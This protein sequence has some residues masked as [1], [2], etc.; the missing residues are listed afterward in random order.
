MDADFIGPL[1]P[2]FVRFLMAS[3]IPGRESSLS[4]SGLSVYLT[5]RGGGTFLSVRGAWKGCVRP[6]YFSICTQYHFGLSTDYPIKSHVDFDMVLVFNYPQVCF[7]LSSSPLFRLA[8]YYGPWTVA[9]LFLFVIMFVLNYPRVCSSD[10]QLPMCLKWRGVSSVYT[11]S[12]SFLD[13]YTARRR[14]RHCFAL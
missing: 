3:I 2:L 13:L 6:Q 10:F 5:W 11:P 14:L 9:V 12:A 8:G 1:Q 4:S 7:D